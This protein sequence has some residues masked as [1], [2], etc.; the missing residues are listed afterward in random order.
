MRGKLLIAS[1]ALVDPNFRRTVVLVGEHSAHGAMGLVLNRP[2]TVSVDEA[3]PLLAELADPSGLVYVGGPVQEDAVVVLAEF[4]SPDRA[5]SLVIGP[6][7]FVPGEVDDLAGLGPLGRSRVFAGYAGW[8]ASQL[9][10]ELDEAAWIVAPAEP[11]DVF[12]PDPEALW[13]TAL[14][15]LGGKHAILALLPD[16][17]RV[18]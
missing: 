17:P 14:R 4:A 13:R 15:R 3:V 8:A 18:N 10:A 6:V 16:D 11:D 7:G 2:S 1:P 5:A 9:E 12:T